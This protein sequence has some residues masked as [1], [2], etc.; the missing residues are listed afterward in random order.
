M[1]RIILAALLLASPLLA[2]TNNPPITKLVTLKYASPDSI[3]NIIQMFGVRVQWNGGLRTIAL[4]GSA[5]S[6]AAAETAIK[7]LDVAPKNIELVVQ[8]LVG[9]N[10]AAPGAIP[11]DLGD[12]VAQLKKTFAFKEYSLLDTLTLRTRAGSAAD[13]T[14]MISPAGSSIPRMTQ[15][16]IRSAS[17]S[18]DGVIRIERMHAGLRIPVPTG[19]KLEYMNTGIDQDIDV[20]E[21]QKVVVGRA[22]LEGPDKALFLIL[23]AKV[24][25]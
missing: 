18:D 19:Q 24:V 9:A 13:T 5:E 1:K 11:A 6:I 16:S 15:F 23:T 14:G 12:V 3:N 21:G 8:F 17:V 7:Q 25:Q 10:Q 22:S 20:K 2:Q 4:T